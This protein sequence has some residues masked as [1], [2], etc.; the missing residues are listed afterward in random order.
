MKNLYLKL[1]KELIKFLKMNEWK[2]L[3][4]NIIIIVLL[5]YFLKKIKCY[6][7]IPE[8][9][10]NDDM[11]FNDGEKEYNRLV[12]VK[13]F[14]NNSINTYIKNQGFN[15]EK[16]EMSEINDN[17]NGWTDGGM[18]T[19]SLYKELY[20]NSVKSRSNTITYKFPI[21]DFYKEKY[22]ITHSFWLMCSSCSS[23]FIDIYFG[24]DTSS[25][26]QACQIPEP[27]SFPILI[28]IKIF[29]ETDNIDYDLSNNIVR[30]NIS[31]NNGVVKTNIKSIKY[32]RVQL[33]T[34][35]NPIMS[36]HWTKLYTEINSVDSL[37]LFSFS[38]QT[39]DINNPCVEGYACIGGGCLLCDESCY[40]CYSQNSNT[41]CRTF[42]SNIATTSISDNGKCNIGY[43]DLSKFGDFTFEDVPPPRTNRMT[44]S[45]WL[46]YKGVP[47]DVQINTKL[48]SLKY[49][50]NL[51]SCKSITPELDILGTD[52]S[53]NAILLNTD[54][55]IYV[56]CGFSKDHDNETK[57]FLQVFSENTKIINKHEK[58]SVGDINHYKYFFR[59]NEVIDLSFINFSSFLYFYMKSFFIFKEYLP[60]PYDIKY[61]QL[62]KFVQPSFY[63][64]IIF[65]MPLDL[66][67]KK[68]SYYI[69]KYFTYDYTV[70]ENEKSLFLADGK[71]SDFRAPRTFKR[72][73][74][75]TEP[76]K[77][78]DSPDL[79]LIKD[80]IKGQFDMLNSDDNYPFS[81]LANHFLDVISSSVPS[82]GVQCP[83]DYSMTHGISE[84]KGICNYD[85]KN[86]FQNVNCLNQQDDILTLKNNFKCKDTSNSYNMFY[87]CEG[88]DEENVFFYSHF[89]TPGNIILDLSNYNLVSYFVEF[90]IYL[91]NNINRDYRSYEDNFYLFYLNSFQLYGDNLGNYYY[92]V[93]SIKSST[94]LEINEWNHI[95][96]CILYD[97]KEHQLKRTKGFLLKNNNLKYVENDAHMEKK[98]PLTKIYFCDHEPSTCDGKDILWGS[99]FY[100]NIRVWDG[101]KAQPY[102][103]ERYDG[104]YSNSPK[105]YSLLIHLP[106]KGKYIANNKIHDYYQKIN[107]YDVQF[108]YNQWNF[109]QYNY[110]SDFDIFYFPTT[111]NPYTKNCASGCKRCFESDTN[112][113][114]CNT[115]YYLSGQTCVA[116]SSSQSFFKLPSSIDIPKIVVDYSIY[117]PVI[118]IT[119][120]VKLFGFF[121]SVDGTVI[122][123]GDTL[124]ISYNP[125]PDQEYTG[126]N[127]VTGNDLSPIVL[128]N[129]YY[130]RENVGK[131]T[132][133]SVAHYNKLNQT[134]YPSMTRFEVNDSYC[135]LKIDAPYNLNFHDI[136][137]DNDTYALYHNLKIYQT[138][139]VGAFYYEIKGS[140]P[141]FKNYFEGKI[142]N[143][144]DTELNKAYECSPDVFVPPSSTIFSSCHGNCDN[145]CY[146]KSRFDKCACNYNNN[147]AKLF[148]GNYSL[149]YCIK[150]KYINF[151]GSQ[152][153]KSN[154]KTAKETHKFTMHFWVYANNYVDKQFGGIEV[155]W[156][157][158]GTISV[159]KYDDDNYYFKC[160]SNMNVNLNF[161]FDVGKWNFL[162]CAINYPN[163]Y[164]YLNTYDLSKSTDFER[165]DADYGLVQLTTTFS[166]KDLSVEK[167]WGVLFFQYIRLWS[168]AIP[169]SSF[170]SKIKISGLTKFNNL[171]HDWNCEST[172]INDRVCNSLD[173]STYNLNI[174]VDSII[175]SNYIPESSYSDLSF[176]TDK[177]EYFDAKTNECV[178][179]TALSK[180]SNG[181]IVINNVEVSYNHNYGI[182]FWLLLENDTHVNY[183]TNTLK[184]IDIDWQYHMKIGLINENNILN[185]FCFPQNYPPYSDILK[186]E[187]SASDEDTKYNNKLNKVLNG[188]S[189]GFTN[190]AG[191]WLWI[192]CSLSY[193]NRK[194]YFNEVEETLKP[195]VLYN[196]DNIDVS[197]DAPLGWFFSDLKNPKS[198]LTIQIPKLRDS[199]IFFR[200]LYLFRDFIP[201]NFNYKYMDLSLMP[202]ETFPAL[203]LAINFANYVL[204]GASLKINYNT[205]SAYYKKGTSSVTVTL[206]DITN[207][208]LSSNFVFLP[209]C[210]GE[211]NEKYNSETNLCER[212]D[213]CDLVSLNAIY[214][215][216]ENTPLICKENYFLNINSDGSTTCKSSC[217]TELRTPGS[218]LNI[219][220]CNAECLDSNILRKCPHNLN[221]LQ[222]YPSNFEC[223]TSY[224]RVDYHCYVRSGLSN[225]NKGALFYSNCNYPYNF[226]HTFSNELLLRIKDGYIIELWFMIDNVICDWSDSS[227][228]FY[229]LYAYPHEIYRQGNKFYY[230]VLNSSPHELKQ[231]HL[232]EWNKFIIYADTKKNEITIFQ[233]FN[234]DLKDEDGNDNIIHFGTTP[235]NSL[236]IRFCSCSGSNIEG[237]KTPL[238]GNS[239]IKFGSVYYNNFRIWDLTLANI[240][241][242]QAYNSK[243]YTNIPDSLLLNYPLT[244]DYIDNNV[245][246]D[247]IG[248]YNE[249]ISGVIA[250]NSYEMGH[251]DK[252]IIYNYSTKFDWGN[253][254]PNKYVKSMSG[255][256]I[257]SDDCD[258][259]CKRC[260]SNTNDRCYE[261]ESGFILYGQKCIS[262]K[263]NFY[264]KTPST[265]SSEY[266]FVTS[267]SS[268]DITKLTSFTLSFWIKFY[269]VLKGVNT[270]NPQILSLSTITYLAF[271]RSDK[272]L[273]LSQNS[274]I[275]FEDIN[276]HNYIG[277]WIPIQIA[278]YISTGISDIYPHMFTLNVNR[279][280]IPF[281]TGYSIPDSGI[282]F[283]QIKIGNEIIAL[284]NNMRIYSK[285]YQ[286]AYGKIMS[287]NEDTGRDTPDLF[288]E[289]KMN[290]NQN[291]NCINSDD[292]VSNT[293]IV[294]VSDYSPY[295]DDE[296]TLNKNCHL[297]DNKFLEVYYY[298][299]SGQYISACEDCHSDCSEFC[300][301]SFEQTCSCDTSKGVYW[302]RRNITLQTYCEKIPY[303][304]FSNI[305]EINIPKPPFTETY[306]YTIEFWFFVYSYNLRTN[307]FKKITI[308][309]NYH[310]KIVISNENVLRVQ[311]VPIFDS[312][313]T[314]TDKYPDSMT[315]SIAYYKWQHIRCGTD[316]LKGKYFLLNN[317]AELRAKKINFPNYESI[318][319]DIR[320]DG[321]KY[322]KI[323]RSSDSYTNFGYIFI[324]ELKL[325]QQYNFQYLDS[326]YYDFNDLSIDLIKKNFPGLLWYYKNLYKDI[327]SKLIL[328]EELSE[329]EIQLGY[330]A[331][332][333]GYNIVDPANEGKTDLLDLCP[334]DEVYL[335]DELKCISKSSSPTEACAQYADPI[336]NCLICREN[337]KYLYVV[338]GTCL[339]EC[340]A[341][342]FGND[343]ILQCRECHETCY[344]CSNRFYNNCT[345][346]TGS[347]YFNYKENTCIENC[348][349]VGLTKSNTRPNIC[350]VFDAEASLVNVDTV[351]PIDVNTFDHIQ[352]TVIGAT[353]TGY[354]TYWR[355]NVSETNRINNEL[356]YTDDLLDDA[357]PFTGDLTLLDTPLDHTFFKVGHQ[358]VFE[359]DI[360]KENDG[361]FVTV[362]VSWV[363]TMNQAPTN[364]Y[365]KVIPTIGLLQST[366]FVIT[367]YDFIDENTN[368]ELLEYFFYYIEDQTSSIINLSQDW[369]RN[370]EIYSNFSVR[371]YQPAT[372]KLEIYCKCRDQYNAESI[373][374]TKI[375]IVNHIDD[376]DN[377]VLTDVLNNY[378]LNANIE[379]SKYF[380]RSEF[381]KSISIN[382]YREVRPN[383]YYSTFETS[384]DGSKIIMNDPNCVD[385]YCNGHGEC[386]IIDV[387]IACDCKAAYVG[388]NCNVLKTGY[389]KLAYYFQEMYARVFD[390][391]S[392]RGL[393]IGDDVLF[394]SI[395]NIFYAAQ[396]FFQD[397]IFFSRYLIEY[398][399][400]LKSTG[401]SYIL[402]SVSYVDKIFDF[403]DFY[404]NYYYIKLNKQKL[405]NKISSGLPFR[406][407]TLLLSQQ[408]NYESSFDVY[409]T[410]LEELT[411]FLL[412]NGYDNY[413]YE[414]SHIHYK[415]FKITEAFSDSEYYEQNNYLK[416]YKSYILFMDCLI[417]K[418]ASFNYY[419]NIIEYKQYPLSWESTFYPNMTSQ[420]LSLKIYD[421]RGKEVELKDCE[422]EH[423]IEI[424]LSFN[425]YQWLDYIN[426]QKFLFEPSN[427]KL[428]DDPIFRD[429]IFVNDSGAV[430]NDTVEQ[431]IEQYYRHYN[432]SGIYYTPN[433]KSIYSTKGITFINFTSDTDYLI[434][435]SNHLTAFSS[436]LIPNVMEFLI[437]GRFFYLKKTVLFKWKGNYFGNPGFVFVFILL[438]LYLF[439]CFVYFWYD[440]GYYIECEEL[441]HLKKEI[442]KVHNPYNQI[443]PGVNDKNIEK[444]IPNFNPEENN[445]NEIKH[446]FDNVNF[447][448]DRDSVKNIEDAD[449]EN[450][451]NINSKRKSKKPS[452][453][454]DYSKN[455]LNKKSRNKKFQSDNSEDDDNGNSDFHSEESNRKKKKKDKKDKKELSEKISNNTKKLNFFTSS[456]KTK[457]NFVSLSKFH[458][459]IDS[460]NNNFPEDLANEK[461]E[462]LKALEAYTNLKFPTK[463]FIKWNIGTRHILLGPILNR[464]LFTPRWKKFTILLTQ[465][466]INLMLI[467]II[468]TAKEKILGS[469]FGKCLALSILTSI[470][471]NI[472]IY[473]I[474][475]F[476]M[477]SIYQRRRLYQL[478]MKGGQ[479]VVIK[480][481]NNLRSQNNCSSL[482]GLIICIIIWGV[483]IYITFTFV[484]VWKIQ[485]SAFIITT[486]L[487]EII[488]LVFGELGVELFIGIFYHFRRKSNCLRDFGEWLNRLR[489][490]RTLWP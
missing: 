222:N 172:A 337:K 330:M 177:G 57:G 208:Q 481:F 40:S 98:L 102:I 115:G 394:N 118:T 236:S 471:S 359:L 269:G 459:D 364:G 176:C 204:T 165:I 464:T 214:C 151:A 27:L 136:S 161:T 113:Y 478:V 346:C 355:F 297:D 469:T 467:S 426:K 315:Q 155:K 477:T 209:L 182:A 259:S 109:P 385:T 70:I 376:E 199:K 50:G 440:R 194:Y 318:S 239:N 248:I 404:Y 270:K 357:S 152:I 380:S 23:S 229:I 85:C 341:T 168:D 310:N 73:N 294:C 446:M 435:H 484:A 37:G 413:E 489:C 137:F 326:K 307:N 482:I 254:H 407:Y 265:S 90:W 78:Y 217:E 74:L 452:Y 132:F 124:K 247:T 225:E 13:Y 154:V 438:M 49:T 12:S 296:L 21:Q 289:F 212:I 60:D 353:A 224:P 245:L 56:K 213:H 416:N 3:S 231:V 368:S 389:S 431:R 434:F 246:T 370:N 285:F 148:I 81:C 233:N 6:T 92:Y 327:G 443:D 128:A 333:I 183:T 230:V 127:L 304:D 227:Q 433:E 106:M 403:V 43:V 97:P 8:K 184:G 421:Y 462:K 25:F 313:N 361:S 386:D 395:Y 178:K 202:S 77:K 375:T 350:V 429:P 44:F 479:L 18:N 121:S 390:L 391:I 134:Y 163:A 79:N 24:S 188:V 378:D 306:E 463:D 273:I 444:M 7:Y 145:D 201:S 424:Y 76:N 379:D 59:E 258:I 5:N 138:F 39:C 490:Y 243:I 447:D 366:T 146:I 2:F 175:T 169:S 460:Q 111:L 345:E 316:L 418:R 117:Q 314:V 321:Y 451:F 135:P 157:G 238:C 82:C 180:I 32:I 167:N 331:D 58:S 257:L 303:I 234:F 103:I 65:A 66:L 221:D 99:A 119:F 454:S 475:F 336:S 287:K 377:Y 242:I 388:N 207:L 262:T 166:I 405:N 150:T 312:T 108:S 96:L 425:S 112:C 302:L 35:C 255:T 133:I 91:D 323:Y 465:I 26:E 349:T 195:E 203:S 126:L 411:Q 461:E 189:K 170:L 468:L 332:Y 293:N 441:M 417:S 325:W 140:I 160:T 200:S 488:D 430:L 30:Y 84:N 356:G 19:K 422:S 205:Y 309:W 455:I 107:F 487:S 122:R 114:E 45:F 278:N 159:K 42:C 105:I 274:K 94:S 344:R 186:K 450:I 181:K 486:I 338:D 253:E 414:S 351:T 319:E 93:D 48:F 80:V 358:Y 372:T 88:N 156:D 268:S 399:D 131:W 466:Y 244:L 63:S 382:P 339:D 301:R 125:T 250:P 28:S 62:E 240:E 408:T 320:L 71:N 412:N 453:G 367:C 439:A 123:F 110:G 311:C 322:F 190:I 31:C 457:A 276:F 415:I 95:I 480:G 192:Q 198:I 295:F 442:I 267:T 51:I 348:E 164:F 400:Y 33:R 34:I 193:Y 104:L 87:K 67:E 171:L 162:H 237:Y 360:I 272:A 219:G 228:K 449:T 223:V 139:L 328:K 275:A 15:L 36:F 17:F 437:D 398:I 432:L 423:P 101:N 286:G 292:L 158:H 75:L 393:T 290:G 61:F 226:Q 197:N 335:E 72:L 206:E 362:T 387:T 130:F 445:K 470:L 340:P 232:Y 147:Q 282:T 291:N 16:D 402:Q 196:Y 427:Y 53:N 129:Y 20:E 396:F 299:T 210:K 420:L 149:F 54:I 14:T 343:K 46:Y 409:L 271:R 211:N 174:P 22:I 55:W 179:F 142:N 86:I 476:F 216:E 373:V 284:F 11:F 68:S 300:Y 10:L 100:K 436:M 324:R 251:K 9:Y 384:L 185:A 29:L 52:N 456:D 371:Y 143:C 41:N 283:S 365:I 1:C 264:L 64:E 38:G 374:S 116:I 381:L 347:L 288:I 89:F 448:S 173:S 153:S 406:N 334:V 485:K 308:E 472:F 4:L 187:Y 401:S 277:K 281:A 392:N 473:L 191:K 354:T 260:Y 69:I 266:S 397:E 47:N 256:T 410:K 419:L 363:L 317:Q 305:K 383:Q 83:V 352:A 280:D 298:P 369:S 458:N 220:I 483:C 218:A 474:A 252:L 263:E 249:D 428:P 329:T 279:S 342:Y 241:T 141:F 235:L 120:W 144:F 215:M 261:C